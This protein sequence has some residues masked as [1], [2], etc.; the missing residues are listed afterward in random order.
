M[1]NMAYALRYEQSLAY[2]AINVRPDET[3]WMPDPTDI[4]DD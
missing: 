3:G 2:W 1:A 4:M